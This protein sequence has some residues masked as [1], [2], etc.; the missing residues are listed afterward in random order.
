MSVLRAG[1][2]TGL[3]GPGRRKLTTEES[4]VI[5][6]AKRVAVEAE[7]WAVARART[8]AKGV[9]DF[10]T[11]LVVVGGEAQARGRLAFAEL[12]LHTAVRRLAEKQAE[13]EVKTC[14]Q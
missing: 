5:A 1:A 6:A 7:Q 11:T 8:E 9:D 4:A 3:Y 10:A 13:N 14:Q 12:E 2:E